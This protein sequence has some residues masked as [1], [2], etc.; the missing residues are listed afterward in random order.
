MLPRVRALHEVEISGTPLFDIDQAVAFDEL[1][2]EH[3]STLSQVIFK[4]DHMYR[5]RACSTA[6]RTAT[7][8][9]IAP[10]VCTHRA[11]PRSCAPPCSCAPHTP[12]LLCSCSC[13]SC[14][15]TPA[16]LLLLPCAPAPCSLHLCSLHSLPAAPFAPARAARSP[17]GF[18]TALGHFQAPR[19]CAIPYLGFASQHLA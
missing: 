17:L 19:V 4:G 16:L 11:A 6:E 5:C 15:C 10:I 14:S 3:L 1:S 9:V 13:S 7:N 18:S 12:V 8:I 2:M